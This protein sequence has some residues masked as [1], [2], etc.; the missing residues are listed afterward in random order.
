MGSIYQTGFERGVNAGLDNIGGDRELRQSDG[1]TF[2]TDDTNPSSFPA[3]AWDPRS[4]NIVPVPGITVEYNGGG[5]DEAG[6]VL[7]RVNDG[8]GGKNNLV[9]FDEN[10]PSSQFPYTA[11]NLGESIQC[12]DGEIDCGSPGLAELLLLSLGAISAEYVI[13]D[14]GG[15]VLS[16]INPGDGN[17]VSLQYA[18][19]IFSIAS[20]LVF[21]NTSGGSWSVEEI[22]VRVDTGSHWIFQDASFS[23]SVPDGGSITFTTCEMDITNW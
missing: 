6:E 19:T 11:T 9:L 7:V 20:D 1:T 18:S 17:H 12:T 14:G 16:T 10:S 15:S 4:G 22:E 13:K 5:N 23:A 21:E 3:Q 2:S 8:S